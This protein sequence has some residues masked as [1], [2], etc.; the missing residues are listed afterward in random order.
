MP[1]NQ[2]CAKFRQRF[3]G[4]CA[5]VSAN[6]FLKPTTSASLCLYNT[7]I[8]FYIS[9]L[10][11]YSQDCPPDNTPGRI[12]APQNES[13]VDSIVDFRIPHTADRHRHGPSLQILAPWA[14]YDNTHD[15]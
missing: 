6:I 4:I 15:S 11:C 9:E 3:I 2:P 5:L 12:E 1:R 7:A 8:F 10:E 14:G 13:I